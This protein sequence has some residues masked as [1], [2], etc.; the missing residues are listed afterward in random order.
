M[1]PFFMTKWL[2]RSGI[3]PLLPSV[4]RKLEGGGKYLR[5]Y[6]DCLLAAPLGNLEPLGACL[7][8][9]GPDVIDLGMGSP[10]FDLLPTISAKLT[11]DK[12]GWPPYPGL[13]ELRA[14]VADRLFSDHDLAFDPLSEVL[15][16]AGGLGA[17][18]TVADAFINPGDRV[19]LFNPTSPLFPYVFQGRRARLRWLESWVEDGRLRFRLDQLASLLRGARLLVVQTPANPTGGVIHPDDLAQIAWWAD[20]RDV[21]LLSDEVFAGYQHEGEPASIGT[22]P[23][24]DKRTLTVGSVSKSHALASTRVGW[25]A[26]NRHLLRPCLAAAALRDPFVSTL[27]Q[28]VALAALRGQ[29]DALQP[30]LAGI[31]SRRRYA[32]DRIR[33]L[34]FD[35]PWPGGCFFLWVPV[36]RLGM[37]G[38]EFAAALLEEQKVRVIP[39]DLFGPGGI[40]HVRLSLVAEDGR[41]QEGLNRI[42]TFVH[43]Y[44]NTQATELARAA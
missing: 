3:A 11:A 28:Q 29:R 39:G 23:R 19:V 42:T 1:V 31:D 38:R 20:R 10:R 40:G 44:Q 13:P 9:L 16:T 21:L 4:R 33:S 43:E 26:A 14:A 25:L 37:S 17:V 35:V 8:P 2:V 6:S 12:R 22:L 34:E 32:F 18:Q 5:Y 36:W 15:I 30:I 7:E 41:L 24:A 27:G